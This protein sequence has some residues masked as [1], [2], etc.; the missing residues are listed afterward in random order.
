MININKGIIIVRKGTHVPAPLQKI[1]SPAIDTINTFAGLIKPDGSYTVYTQSPEHYYF[2]QAYTNYFL[3]GYYNDEGTASVFWQNAD[4]LLIDNNIIDKDIFLLRDSSH[5]AGSIGGIITFSTPADQQDF[6]GITVLAKNINNGAFYSYNFGKELGDYKVSNIPYGTYELVAQK[7]GLEN[8]VSQTVIIDPF[9][10]Q[11]T[12]INL[13]FNI[14]DI[15]DFKILPNNIV[16]YQ[17][18]PNPFNP[19]TKIS[20]YLPQISTVKLRVINILGETV[21]TLI[22]DELQSGNHSFSFD[23]SHLASGIYLF[24]LESNQLMLSRKMLLLK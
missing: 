5:G 2:L 11:I 17:N 23:G 15:E 24:T 18:Y 7:I 10:N 12:G 8:A 3:P 21:V 22:N 13:N 16:L 19:T 9:N 4:S 14:T 1:N 6:E 20:F